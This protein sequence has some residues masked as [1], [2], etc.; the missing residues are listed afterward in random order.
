[1]LAGLI[2]K[3]R[4]RLSLRWFF[5]VNSVLLYALAVVFAGNGVVALQEA[6]VVPVSSVNIPTIHALGM[7]PSLQVLG[8]QAVLVLTAMV[9]VSLNRRE[10]V[11]T[12]DS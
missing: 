10:E 4:E 8:L 12:E 11:V 1:V 5:T 2:F 3:F 7:Y 6:G 9:F